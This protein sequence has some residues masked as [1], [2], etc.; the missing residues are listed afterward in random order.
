MCARERVRVWEGESECKNVKREQEREWVCVAWMQESESTRER[1][2]ERLGESGWE[3]GW[4]RYEIKEI[5]PFAK[6]WQKTK[7]FKSLERILFS[8]SLSQAKKLSWKQ[9]MLFWNR[10]YNEFD[11]VL[12]PKFFKKDQF[13]NKFIHINITTLLQWHQ[14]QEHMIKRVCF[15]KRY[16]ARSEFFNNAETR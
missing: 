2:R 10:Q 11:D 7:Y 13:L 4:E 15:I 16:L 5:Q 12:I 14:W 3:S 6:I 8:V 1:E 9:W